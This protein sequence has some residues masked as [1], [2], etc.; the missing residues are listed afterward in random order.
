MRSFPLLF[1]V[2]KEIECPNCHTTFQVDDLTYQSIVDQVRSKTF[3]DELES[4]IADL[5]EKFKSR[6]R[7]NKIIIEREFE[8]RLAEQQQENAKLQNL[9]TRLSGELENHELAKRSE[10]ARLE[11]QKANE[12]HEALAAKDNRIN[13][14]AGQIST[15]DSRHKLELLEQQTAGKEEL[16]KK[17]EQLTELRA[18]LQADS[19]SAEKRESELRALHLQQLQDK[20]TEIDRL[21]DFKA[22]LSTKMIGETLEQHCAIQFSQAQSMGLYPF[23]S[24]VKDN[25]AVDGTKGDFIFRDYIEGT[26]YVSIMFEMKNEVDS[27]ATKHKNE[28][29]LK[30][31]DEDR[32]KKQCEYAVLVSMLE[33]GNELYDTGIVDMSYRYPKMLV[34]R[35]QFFLPV[36]RLITEGSRKGFIERKTLERR[37]EEATMQT[38]DFS[39]FE[40]RINR[41]RDNFNKNVIAAHKKFASATEG[42]D[43]TIQALEQQIKKL[44]EIKANFEA[45]EQKLLKANELAEEDLTVKKLTHGAP[46]V[47]KMIEDEARNSKTD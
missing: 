36:L 4:R 13:Q 28:D 26:E 17:D 46:L 5:E 23:A 1:L 45:S 30:K 12:L 35:P 42:I 25:I 8:K 20:Q 7:S 41:F 33:Q 3:A 38:R 39:K 27:T 19:L 11:M 16:R 24:F 10:I 15:I 22:R 29:F 40:E 14:L 9:I 43:K 37:L 34:I 18:R 47:R 31:L 44:R 6:E 32:V 2:M 21:K